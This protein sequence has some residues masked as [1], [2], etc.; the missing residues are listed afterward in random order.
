MLLSR[1]LY[2]QNSFNIVFFE[3]DELHNEFKSNKSQKRNA[4]AKVI[5]KLLANVDQGNGHDHEFAAIAIDRKARTSRTAYSISQLI[6]NQCVWHFTKGRK[7]PADPQYRYISFPLSI[8][9]SH[10][11]AH[12]ALSDLFMEKVR[13]RARVHC[14]GGRARKGA[15]A[16]A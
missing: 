16:R 14:C 4:F 7:N 5:C 8:C 2:F 6:T 10:I 13:A 3:K 1:S 12:A 9:P 11:S 15:R